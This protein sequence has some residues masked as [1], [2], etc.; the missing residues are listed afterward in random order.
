MCF[1]LKICY[2]RIKKVFLPGG[3]FELSIKKCFFEIKK[4]FFSFFIYQEVD[5]CLETNYEGYVAWGEYPFAFAACLSQEECYRYER[6]SATGGECYRYE[7]GECYRYDCEGVLQVRGAV[8]LA[9]R[10][11]ILWHIGWGL[12]SSLAGDLVAH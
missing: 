3:G 6:G 11:E 8:L 1:H 5:L 12:C 9:H 7:R 4:F 10:L 2:F